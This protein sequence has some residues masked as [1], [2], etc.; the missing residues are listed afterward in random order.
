MKKSLKIKSKDRCARFL[1]EHGIT[2]TAQRVDIGFAVL[3]G[4]EH[5]SAEDV[6]DSVNTGTGRPRVSKATV[7]NT[8]GLFVEKGL[9]REVIA[10]PNKTF[11]DPNTAPHHHFYDAD[12]GKLVDIDGADVK[13]VG[14]PPLPKGKEMAGV[15][16]VVRLR[17]SA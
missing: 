1:R 9:I 17:D 15:D 7:Y 14:L 11:Y 8:L 3:S 16:V 12:A 6:F 5:L 13:I 2:P 4:C 10:D